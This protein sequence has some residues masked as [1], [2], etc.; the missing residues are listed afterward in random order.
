MLLKLNKLYFLYKKKHINPIFIFVIEF[1][2]AKRTRNKMAE[3][4]P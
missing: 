3:F 4:T 2:P 1:Y